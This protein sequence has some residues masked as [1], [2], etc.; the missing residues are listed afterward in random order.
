MGRFYCNVTLL[1]TN[2]DAVREVAPRPA[3]VTFQDDAVVVFAEEDDEGAPR[4]GKQLSA[5][6]DCIAVSI[7]IHDDDILMVEVHDRG[8]SVVGGAVPDPAEYFGIDPEMLTDIDPALLEAVGAP[9]P[10]DGGGM[11]DPDV[12]VGAVQ[13]G[14]VDAVRAALAEDFVFATER[15][16]AF[17]KALGLPLAAVGWG[18][19][20][21]S[22]GAQDYNGPPLTKI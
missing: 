22:R 12:I 10:F 11:P 18:Y 14:D 15:H 2:V 19:Q 4:S 1:G 3:F 21:L 7:A 6:L 9:S 17:A 20:Y 8:R 5:A 16:E 13:R